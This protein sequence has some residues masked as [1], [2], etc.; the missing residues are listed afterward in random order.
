MGDGRLIS[1]KDTCPEDIDEACQRRQL[2]TFG[3]D[4]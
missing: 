4:A 3:N 1:V 2:A